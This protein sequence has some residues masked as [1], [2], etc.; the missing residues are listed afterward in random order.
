MDIFPVSIPRMHDP[1]GPRTSFTSGSGRIAQDLWVL[2]STMPMT[3]PN[4]S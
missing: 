1:E 2:G 4:G 3:A